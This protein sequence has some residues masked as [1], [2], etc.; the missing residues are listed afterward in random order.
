MAFKALLLLLVGTVAGFLNV[1]AGGGSFLTLSMLIFMGLP[2]TVANGTNR[3]AIFMQNIMA[4]KK[5][6]EFKVF[7]IRFSLMVTVPAVIGSLA[8][9]YA[10][11]AIPDATFKK[12]LAFIMIAITLVT[13][14]N[15]IEKLS[16]REISWGKGRWAIVILMFLAIGFYGGFVQAGVGFLI[17]S[18]MVVAGFDLIHGN[19]VKV[20]VILIFTIFA[21]VIFTI[22]GKAN[23]LWGAVLGVGNVT[24]AY[25]AT[26]TAIKKGNRFV[27]KVVFVAIMIMA[28]KLLLN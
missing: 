20:F 22:Q 26:V 14:L 27:Q 28:I 8:G 18:A 21:L 23:Y 13:M 6:H 12:A 10:A 11:T 2:P 16:S 5:F 7:P 24:G 19:A 1:L 9:A 15:P 3:V 25:L 17:L 4:V